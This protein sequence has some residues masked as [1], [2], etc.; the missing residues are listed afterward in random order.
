MI[1]EKQE[2]ERE[3]ELED[4]LKPRISIL[5]ETVMMMKIG[6]RNQSRIAQ[7]NC[8]SWMAKNKKL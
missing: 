3:I 8:M 7:N 2:T 5:M 1:C 6:F 4:I